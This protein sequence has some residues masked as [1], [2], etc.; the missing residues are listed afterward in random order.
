MD[1][2]YISTQHAMIYNNCQLCDIYQ[3]ISYIYDCN[4][5]DCHY[6]TLCHANLK[7]HYEKF[8]IYDT[9]PIESYLDYP[10]DLRKY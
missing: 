4:S 9:Y 8:L 5:D 2:K 10:N 3:T 7:S 1:T 6:S